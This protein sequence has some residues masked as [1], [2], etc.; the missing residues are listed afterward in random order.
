[1]YHPKAATVTRSEVVSILSTK[2]KADEKTIFVFGFKTQFGG[3]KTTGFA[4][5]YDSLEDAFDVEPSYRLRRSNPALAK[6]TTSRKSVREA[7]NKRKK[8]FATA[9]DKGK[10][11]RKG[12]DD[13]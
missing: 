10:R 8:L 13:E 4:C 7:K 5:I 9:K 11:K 12:A 2:F 3:G 1:M 6:K